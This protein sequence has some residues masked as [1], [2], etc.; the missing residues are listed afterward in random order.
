MGYIPPKNIYDATIGDRK[1]KVDIYN[2]PYAEFSAENPLV[3][4]GNVVLS[5]KTRS[6]NLDN[7]KIIGDL[8]ISKQKQM[9]IFP[10]IVEGAFICRSNTQMRSIDNP[11]IKVDIFDE[12]F[13]FPQGVIEIDCSHSIPSLTYLMDRIPFA[14]R[15]IIVADALFNNLQGT[16]LI[17]AHLLLQRYPNLEIVGEKK[18]KT[19]SE[20]LANT[21]M[22]AEK[23]VEKPVV[24]EPVQ[25][26]VEE[27]P[28]VMLKTADWLDAADILDIVRKDKRRKSFKI[29]DST[30]ERKIR[31]FIKK[32][33]YQTLK[34]E[35]GGTPVIC[36]RKY[37]LHSLV[38]ML[39]ADLK[40]KTP[41]KTESKPEEIVVQKPE[42]NIVETPV[43]KEEIKPEEPAIQTEDFCNF[44]D[45]IKICKADPTIQSFDISD[46]EL[47]KEVRKYMKTFERKK[48]LN[49]QT[50]VSTY[51][52]AKSNVPFV[53]QKV[54]EAFQKEARKKEAKSKVK[55]T[56]PVVTPKVNHT[57][58][59]QK[60]TK[61]ARALPIA[62][63]KYIPKSL[64]KEIIRL[65][66]RNEA[67]YISVLENVAAINTDICETI[68]STHVHIINPKTHERTTSS[69]IKREDKLSLVQGLSS[70]LQDDKRIVWSYIPEDRLIVCVGVLK[71]HTNTKNK[72]SY[73][74]M[75]DNAANGLD[76]KGKKITLQRVLEEEYLDVDF[77]LKQYKEQEK[78]VEKTSATRTGI[79]P[80]LADEQQIK[81]HVVKPV[82]KVYVK[83]ETKIEPKTEQPKQKPIIHIDTPQDL[84]EVRVAEAQINS[85][86]KT[87]NN[88]IKQNLEDVV[89]EE[90]DVAKQLA[91]LDAV[92]DAIVQ[93]AKLKLALSEIGKTDEILKVL[94]M[95]TKNHTK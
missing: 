83:P 64:W 9:I 65:C 16:D 8:D 22:E 68:D 36:I 57:T 91:Q 86:I 69:Y 24:V 17:N 41:M 6:T 42:A 75:R 27:K 15:K 59:P 43:V 95:H 31:D 88:A 12:H 60:T 28:S 78:Q 92:R 70:S 3:V 51:C 55:P 11:K 44:A 20:V 19:L 56:K 85:I 50:G 39:F 2:L 23:P 32:F 52:I 89:T 37:N 46:S 5:D 40:A 61:H 10:R 74:L 80:I 79:A 66:N 71:G 25:K 26:P 76:I 82:K 45:I 4:F 14:T 87:L 94:L 48:L 81:T 1:L 30:L 72:N 21:P 54:I 7:V 53:L 38:E 33:D 90:D 58:K 47:E 18:G 84:C 29:L 77:L 49:E 13:V 34:K 62:I 67:T 73:S 63:K 35:H 93:K